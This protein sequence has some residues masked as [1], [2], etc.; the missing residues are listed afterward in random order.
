MATGRVMK[1]CQRQPRLHERWPAVDRQLATPRCALS[2]L[3]QR[4]NDH[5]HGDV[6][7]LGMPAVVVG[8]ERECSESPP[9]ELRLLELVMPITSIP[10]DRWGFDSASVENCRPSMQT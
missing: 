1:A 8:D 10:Q 4:C 2:V 5:L 7:V 3:H 9:R 6:I